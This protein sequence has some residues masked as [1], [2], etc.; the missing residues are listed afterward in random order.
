MGVKIR[1]KPRSS[2]VWWVF[3]NHNGQRKSKKIG[4][5]RLAKKVADQIDAR[6]K[7]GD[8][9]MSEKRFVEYA[10]TWITEHAPTDYKE[11]TL[12]DYKAI[13]ENYVLPQFGNTSVAQINRLMVKKYLKQKVKDGISTHLADKIKAVISNVMNLAID[14]GVITM[15]PTHRL[16]N[17]Y[18]KSKLDSKGESSLKIDPLT[19]DELTL[20][21]DTFRKHFPKHFPL[22]LT[23]SLTGVR[24]GEVLALKW[25]DIDFNSR[26]ID[27]QRSFSRG[28]FLSTPKNG[29]SR[30]VDMSLQLTEIL[31]RLKHERQKEF[32]E[33]PEWVFPNEVGKLINPNNWRRRIFNKALDIAELRQIKIH[34]LRHTY[35]SLLIQAGESLAYVRD[36]LGHSSIKITVDTYGHL[37]PGAN[38]QAV[39]KLDDIIPS[40]PNHT[41]Y[42]PSNKKD[43]AIVG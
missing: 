5:K 26:F 9:C 36:Q 16:G 27:V 2:G 21:L 10:H 40:A 14:G 30:R 41:L 29:K 19:R 17:I 18:G 12:I 31:W 3:I 38:K 39:D 37:I 6:L 33:M 32:D 22:V 43:S 13:L 34:L 7:L 28:K 35:S 20:L 11:S 23:L 42:A 25:G 1:E 4:E 24:L 15:N 8:Y